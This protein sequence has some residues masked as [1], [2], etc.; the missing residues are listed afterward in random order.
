MR[1]LK[2]VRDQ[3]GF[4]LIELLVVITIIAVLSAMLVPRLLG[5]TDKARASRA[6]ADL[7][8]M[9]NV[10]EIYC[11]DEGEG[12]YPGS[13]NDAGAQGTIANVLQDKGINWTGNNNGIKDPWGT[14]YRY[15]TAQDDNGSI[16]DRKFIF[17]SAGPDQTFDTADDI[18]CSSESATVHNSGTPDV[19]VDD[20]TV[21]SSS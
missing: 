6:M 14:S 1:L 8:A 13:S 3:R 2:A 7:A 15:G 18:W 19:D 9:K 20:N 5:Y 16:D 11:A 4:T 12:R 21:D 10:V 17:Q